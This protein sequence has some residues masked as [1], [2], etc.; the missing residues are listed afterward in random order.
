MKDQ[1]LKKSGAAGGLAALCAWAWNGLFPDY[2]M[3][4]EVGIA[5]AIVLTGV[6]DYLTS[7][8]PRRR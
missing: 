6:V 2:P 3:T 5:V 7:F 4:V 1:T 8:L